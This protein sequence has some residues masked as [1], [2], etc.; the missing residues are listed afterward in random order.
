MNMSSSYQVVSNLQDLIGSSRHHKLGRRRYS[1]SGSNS[2]HRDEE[3]SDATLQTGCRSSGPKEVVAT[4]KAGVSVISS[5]GSFAPTLSK[6]MTGVVST[7]DDDDDSSLIADKVG[8][9]EES[10][11]YTEADISTVGSYAPTLTNTKKSSLGKSTTHTQ[12]LIAVDGHS[13]MSSVGSFAVTLEGNRTSDNTSV[14][15]GERL[16]RLPQNLNPRHTGSVVSSVGSFAPTLATKSQ[17]NGWIEAKRSSRTFDEVS[18]VG[19]YAPTLSTK[20][21]TNMS[22]TPRNGLIETRRK[23]SNK[24]DEVSSVGSYAPTLTTKQSIQTQRNNLIGIHDKQRYEDEVST[25]G[26]H[27]PTLSSHRSMATNSITSDCPRKVLEA[28]HNESAFSDV[29]TLGSRA[30]TLSSSSRARSSRRRRS[31]LR[32]G[33]SK[34]HNPVGVLRNHSNRSTKS[35]N[36]CLSPRNSLTMKNDEDGVSLD[37]YASD[38]ALLG[39]VLGRDDL[40]SGIEDVVGTFLRRGAMVGLTMFVTLLIVIVCVAPV[41]SYQYMSGV[42]QIANATLLALL[43]G[44]NLNRLGPIL[45]N[46]RKCNWNF[47]TSGSMTASVTVQ[48]IAIV[49]VAMMLFLPT[50]VMIDPIM[51]IRCHLVRWASWTSLAFIMCFLTESIDLPLEDADATHAWIVAA[52]V[53]S[54]TVCGAIMPFCTTEAAW[55]MV[56]LTSCGL[57]SVLFVRLFWRG[58]RLLRMPKAVTT[59]DKEDQE[60]AMYSFKLLSIC[61]FVWTTLVIVWTV[62]ALSF[63]NAKPG[64]FFANEW[65]ILTAENCCE[66]LSK[67]AYLSILMEVH[68]LLFDDVSQTARRLGDL[69]S[70]MSAVWDASTDVVIICSGHDHLVNAAVSPSFFQ[71]ETAFGYYSSQKKRNKYPAPVSQDET[72]TVVMEVDPYEGSYRTYEMDLS[73]PM[74]RQEAS[75]MMNQSRNKARIITPIYKQNLQ[76]LSDL[77]C[78]ACTLAFPSGQKQYLVHRNFHCLDQRGNPRKL[79]CEAKIIQL[80]GKA[81]LLVLR[82]AT[83]RVQTK[84][85]PST[86]SRRASSG[87]S[88]DYHGTKMAENSILCSKDTVTSNSPVEQTSRDGI[89]DMHT[90]NVREDV[91]GGIQDCTGCAIM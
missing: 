22:K 34:S 61:L 91:E 37:H 71:M 45:I 46:D 76:V 89:P 35:R 9:I 57:F 12:D 51:G 30:P 3:S 68:E 43:V 16:G 32:K 17:R 70:Y 85:G 8:E 24:Y 80:K 88:Q 52:M 49:A 19:S 72:T 48:C 54:S 39:G 31:S 64:S 62:C 13:T 59:A 36:H 23:L 65:L 33:S 60:R 10:Q 83:Q 55:W 21:E 27:A 38:M 84:D 28:P 78:D 4:P 18:S 6:N 87:K 2:Y 69:R 40:K 56:F 50:P 7:D 1:S 53:A 42:E 67:I 41:S 11:S 44:V 90:P 14:G 20:E 63:R 79:T 77:V 81:F 25:V 66:G 74:S 15:G 5:V 75:K 58:V 47:L 29:S 73:R 82:D 26:S 86:S